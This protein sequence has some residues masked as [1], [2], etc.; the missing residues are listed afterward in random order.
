MRVV[1]ADLFSEAGI[2]E[3]RN[4]GIEVLY[5]PSLNGEAL[6]KAVGDF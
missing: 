1:V 2:D 3:L 5:D 6:G 4:S